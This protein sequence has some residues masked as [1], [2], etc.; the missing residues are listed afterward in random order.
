LGDLTFVRRLS[1][2]AFAATGLASYQLSGGANDSSAFVFKDAD[3]KVLEQCDAL[4]RQFD[5]RGLVYQDVALDAH[6]A[7]LARPFLPDVPLEHIE[8]RFHILRDPLVNALAFPGGS[9]YVTTGLIALL[10]NDDQLAGVLAREVA[11]VLNRHMYR[12]LRSYRTKQL[13]THILQLTGLLLPSGLGLVAYA[14]AGSNEAMAMT[15]TSGYCSEFEREADE[16]AAAA[17]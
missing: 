13:G 8:W 16:F 1:I 12:A 14:I 4:E 5:R 11:H 7:M 9:V 17:L 3:L 6:L 2:A 15:V 10:G